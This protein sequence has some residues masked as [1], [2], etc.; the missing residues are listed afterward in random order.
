[1]SGP[2]K[3]S[4]PGFLAE[5]DIHAKRG[6]WQ[7]AMESYTKAINIEPENKTALIGRTK[8]YIAMGQPQ[9]AIADVDIILENDKHFYKG[10]FQ[11]A[12]AL[13]SAGNFE[14]ALIYY[15]RG[16][17][18]RPDLDDFRLGIQKCQEA[19]DMALD[20][21]KAGKRRGGN[22]ATANMTGDFETLD[23]NEFNSTMDGTKSSTQNGG[24]RRD[25]NKSTRSTK[26]GRGGN[27]ARFEDD[28]MSV[29]STS[30]RRGRANRDKSAGV[31]GELK[32]DKRF[33]EELLGDKTMQDRD[34]GIVDVVS[35]GLK[36]LDTRT[37]FWRQQNPAA[38]KP[39]S[40]Q[41]AGATGRRTANR[42]T[43]STKGADSTQRSTAAGSGAGGAG[44]TRQKRSG[45]GEQRI[46]ENTRYAMQKLEAINSAMEKEEL[47]YALKLAKS[48]LSR[49]NTMDLA[50]KDRI[51]GT[52]YDQ[53]GT[54]YL[55][56]DKL[57]LAV[58]HYRKDLD[59][60][61]KNNFK[62]AYLRALG[63]LGNVYQRQGDTDQ[64]VAMWEKKLAALDD[65]EEER[66]LCESIARCYFSA[67]QYE[68]A[69]DFG[70]RGMQAAADYN[71]TEREMSTTFIVGH[72][73]F[74]LAQYDKAI[75]YYEKYLQLANESGNTLA[76]A[77][78][79]SSLG[80]AH[81]QMGEVSK[82]IVLQQEA[83]ALSTNLNQSYADG[84]T[85]SN[86]RSQ[87]RG[88]SR[89]QSRASNKSGG[90]STG[91]A[92]ADTAAAE[93]GNDDTLDVSDSDKE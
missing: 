59:L 80:N 48:F 20:P 66:E 44:A 8:C 93:G 79:L 71:D 3:G 75:T 28:T 85:G 62:D 11:K 72:S 52:L 16:H 51:L 25:L 54:I 86:S 31:L 22:N 81:L 5:G 34:D 40:R 56:L 23:M 36:Y 91:A 27:T 12:E 39:K 26:S 37:E 35:D 6:D 90:A 83:L 82:S 17:K 53:M 74:N 78:A 88:A 70:E 55:D 38:D 32:E 76:Q 24:T 10:I 33:L 60:A 29:T 69:I 58:I 19:I 30:S 47:T 68:L 89:G 87:S 9:K 7:R 49:L 67:Q 2:V 46:L 45:P 84:G 41:S 18:L 21:K 14:Y 77:N 61:L 43:R 1:M 50:D 42:T 13:F 63:N 92:G 4:V 15:H 73:Y 64:A 65:Q 57:N